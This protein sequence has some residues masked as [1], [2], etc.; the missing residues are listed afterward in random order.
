MILNFISTHFLLCFV[1]LQM[2][3]GIED[4]HL[5][6]FGQP[7]IGNAA[8]ASCFYK[9]IPN[10]FRIT[11][12][13]DIVPHLPPYYSFYWKSYHHFPREVLTTENQIH[14]L[15]IFIFFGTCWFIVAWSWAETMLKEQPLLQLRKD[16][17]KEVWFYFR[18]FKGWQ[19]NG[20]GGFV[21]FGSYQIQYSLNYFVSDHIPMRVWLVDL[22]HAVY[23]ACS[24]SVW[25]RVETFKLWGSN[26][27]WG[28]YH[29]KFSC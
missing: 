28:V 10:T 22:L 24:I 26:T 2:N 7:R 29:I 15:F 19:T 27:H 8:F 13:R 14:F 20:S 4:V 12:N 16:L 21:G 1:L 3:Q 23:F 6:T 11:N 25:S 18:L 5:L 17:H 9:Y